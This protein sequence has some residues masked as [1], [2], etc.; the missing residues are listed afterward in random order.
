MRFIETPI[1]TRAIMAL[2][3]DEEYRLL[4]LGLLQRPE[5]GT[6]IQGSG[7]LRKRVWRV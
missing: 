7:G 4:Q 3:N 6:V 5:R 1:F 2:L